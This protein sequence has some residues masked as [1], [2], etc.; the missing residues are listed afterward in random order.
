MWG[1]LMMKTR[2]RLS[3]SGSAGFDRRQSEPLFVN[4]VTVKSFIGEAQACL[5]QSGNPFFEIL[6]PFR[7]GSPLPKWGTL[8]HLLTL[9]LD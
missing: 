1:G 2:G 7:W 6:R 4:A 3:A 9:R 8:D 5:W